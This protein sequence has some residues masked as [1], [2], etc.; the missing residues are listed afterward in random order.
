METQVHRHGYTYVEES[1]LQSGTVLRDKEGRYI[2][3]KRL[4]HQEDVTIIHTH[5]PNI[6]HLDKVSKYEQT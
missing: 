2:T 3:I 1:T 5:A 4:V 6:G